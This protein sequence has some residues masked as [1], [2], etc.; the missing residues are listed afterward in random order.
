MFVQYRWL[1][2]IDLAQ[3]PWQTPLQTQLN[4]KTRFFY[5]KLWLTASQAKTPEVALNSL[6]SGQ[7]QNSLFPLSI[8]IKH[9]TCLYGTLQ[10]VSPPCVCPTN[11]PV[12]RTPGLSALPPHP[13]HQD[14]PPV[15]MMPTALPAPRPQQPWRAGSQLAAVQTSSRAGCQGTVPVAPCRSRF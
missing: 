14:R 4:P 5:T 11:L 3:I 7:S 1:I 10:E 9:L 2:I 6:V 12:S 8:P 13:H 15:S